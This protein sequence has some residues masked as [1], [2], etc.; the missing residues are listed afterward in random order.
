MGSG[1]AAG[2]EEDDEEVDAYI[3]K[4]V[5]EGSGKDYETIVKR[6]IVNY[7]RATGGESAEFNDINKFENSKEYKL[8]QQMMEEDTDHYLD[9]IDS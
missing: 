9:L 2:D 7:K 3:K 5:K 4:R 8:V 1:D 6:D